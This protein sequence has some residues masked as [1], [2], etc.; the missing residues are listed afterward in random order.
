[1]VMLK[2][3]EPAVALDEAANVRVAEV[4]APAAKGVT[5]GSH[6]QVRYV[7]AFDGLQL[8]TLIV[9]FSGML[10]VFWR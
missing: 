6:V 9:R 4:D 7:F 3:N 8:L 10:P 1:M 5:V 2:L